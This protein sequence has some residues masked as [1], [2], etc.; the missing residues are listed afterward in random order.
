VPK[1]FLEFDEHNRVKP[2]ANYDRVVD[3]M[4]E[5]VKFTLL[6]RSV[7]PYLTDR[8]LGCELRPTLIRSYFFS[9]HER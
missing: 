5:S 4:E 6:T 2:S 1:A 9:Q 7:S 3:V 8:L